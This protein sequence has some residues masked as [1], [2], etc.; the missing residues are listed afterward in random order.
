ML[1]ES[2][3]SLA[4]L[5]VWQTFEWVQLRKSAAYVFKQ[6]GGKQPHTV[7]W[8]QHSVRK[9]R[10][11]SIC[12]NWPVGAKDHLASG[13]MIAN[14]LTPLAARLL[15]LCYPSPLQQCLLYAPSS[16]EPGAPITDAGRP[17]VA[18]TLLACVFTFLAAPVSLPLTVPLNCRGWFLYSRDPTTA[19]PLSLFRIQA[20]AMSELLAILMDPFVRHWNMQTSPDRH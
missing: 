13:G 12:R 19:P 17:F 14:C 3:Q 16:L 9:Q 20:A 2:A 18:L 4:V 6:A 8:N 1:R 10:P 5:T 11:L 7:N 15:A